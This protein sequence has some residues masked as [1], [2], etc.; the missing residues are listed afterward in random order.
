MTRRPAL[1]ALALTAVLAA[2]CSSAPA[3]PR[4]CKVTADI[5]KDMSGGAVGG[6]AMST[7]SAA[8]ADSG[9]TGPLAAPVARAVRDSLSASSDVDSDDMAAYQADAGSF[10]AD[11]QVVHGDCLHGVR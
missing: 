9:T 3:Q 7:Y 8:L 1:A 11:L 10:V 5:T 6:S 4:A 2:G